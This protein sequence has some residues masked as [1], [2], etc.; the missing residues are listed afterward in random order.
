MMDLLDK[1]DKRVFELHDEL[2]FANL[3]S[4]ELAQRLLEEGERVEEGW[5]SEEIEDKIQVALELVAKY[6]LRL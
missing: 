5:S 6:R 3:K 1:Y 2:N 4:D